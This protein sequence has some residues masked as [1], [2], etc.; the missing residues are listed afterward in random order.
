MIIVNPAAGS[1]RR[2]QRRLGEVVAAL[3][4]RGCTVVVRRAALYGDAERLAREAEPEFDAIVAAGGDGTINAVVNGLAEGAPRDLALLPFGTANVLAREIGLPRRSESLAALIADAPAR[5]IWPG[6]IGDRLFLMMAGIGFD[7]E[8][9]AAVNPRLKR[10][11]GK[12]A[13][14]WAILVRLV[15]HR[16]CELSVR[17][18]GIAYRATAMIAAKGRFYAGPFGIA[19]HGDLGEPALNLVLFHDAG[20]IAVLRYLGGLL[21]GRLARLSSVT[22]LRAH[23]VAVSAAEAVPVQAD[24]EIAGNLPAAIAVA[25]QPVPLIRP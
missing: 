6:R 22:L 3:E 10:R 23:S 24:G 20:R 1:P 21:L 15:R 2:S 13:F 11:I 5:P 14:L 16:R 4:R 25:V 19:P 18:D 8:V 12:L 7:A 17:A 9:V